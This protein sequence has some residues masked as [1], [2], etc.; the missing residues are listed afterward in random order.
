MTPPTTTTDADFTRAIIVAAGRGSR[1]G[2]ETEEIPKCMVKVA[3][4]P[5]LHHQLDAL[6]AAGVTDVVIVRGYKGTLIEG[7]GR[8]LRFV[9][10]PEWERNN[11]F[12]SLIYAAAEMDRGFFFSYSDI[13]YAPMVAARLAAAARA[14][15]AAAALIVD[16]R[17]SDAYVGRTLHPVPEAELTAVTGTGHTARI[18]AVG[19]QV[20]PQAEAAGEF[21][22]LAWFSPTGARALLEVWQQALAKGGLEPPFGRARALRHAYLSDGFNALADAGHTLLPVFIDGEW[23]EIDTGQDLAAA[24]PNV[25]GF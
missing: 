25:R 12:A 5:M 9:E 6:A 18:T 16:R 14:T 24:E 7:G 4:R 23:R 20:V 8:P 17:W 15:S 10:N 1:L 21:I 11:I 22:G 2:P 3:G 19:K 13:V